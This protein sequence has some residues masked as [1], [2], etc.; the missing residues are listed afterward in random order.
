MQSNSAITSTP[1]FFSILSATSHRSKF[2]IQVVT[3]NYYRVQ[4]MLLPSHLIAI[5]L[6]GPSVCPLYSTGFNHWQNIFMYTGY[7]TNCCVL[8]FIV[9]K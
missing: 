8:T 3:A 5:T 4:N 7:S 9:G 1:S 2:D 6:F